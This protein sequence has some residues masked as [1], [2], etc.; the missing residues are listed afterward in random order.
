MVDAISAVSFV[1]VV[2]IWWF[3]WRDATLATALYTGA[4]ALLSV[5]A[6]CYFAWRWLTKRARDYEDE[7][8]EKAERRLREAER[9][10]NRRIKEAD[11]YFA[12][13]KREIDQFRRQEML[14]IQA[15]YEDKIEKWRRNLRDLENSVRTERERIQ[16]MKEEIRKALG[17]LNK[18]PN[19]RY[20][21]Q[22]L[23][24]ALSA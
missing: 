15:T 23:N 19:I 14:K 22:R 17:A 3:F 24:K 12:E 6:F 8:M 10:A 5:L 11:M 7:L 18:E 16:K 21:K 1:K 2:K 4:V 13:K 20:L 9:E